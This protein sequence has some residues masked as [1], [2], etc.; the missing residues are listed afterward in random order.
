MKHKL[1]RIQTSLARTLLLAT[2]ALLAAMPINI[3]AGSF[4]AGN[5]V[6]LQSDT[7]TSAAASVS[8]LEFQTSGTGQSAV[9]TVALPTTVAA[10]PANAA[11]TQSGSATSEGYLSRSQD[12]TCLLAAGYNVA[13]GTASVAGTT[14]DRVVARINASGSV[15]TTTRPFGYSAN[16]IRA[17]AS[18]SGSTIYVAGPGAGITTLAFGSQPGSATTINSGNTRSVGIFGNQL[19]GAGTIGTL[20][21]V[22]SGLPTSSSTFTA[23][24]AAIGGTSANQFYFLD[25]DAGV[26][27]VDEVVIADGT[28]GLKKYSFDGTAWTL[29]GTITGS[30]FGVVIVANGSGTDI[31]ATTGTGAAAANN[32]VKYTD[33][34]AYNATG[35]FSSSTILATAAAGKAFR[36]LA[37]APVSSVTVNNTGTPAAGSI[38]TGTANQPLFGFQLSSAGSSSTFTAL[39]LTTAGT[40]TTSDLSNFRVVWDA[41]NSGTYNAGDVIVS[42]SA[43]S[44]ANPI[45][46]TFSGQTLSGSSNYLVIAD[47][48]AGATVGHT[49]TGSIAAAGDVTTSI[50]PIGTATGNQ[51]TVAAAV[52][53]LTMSAVPSSESTAISSLTN[54]ATISTTSQGVPVWQV[55]F[56]NPAGNAGAVTI[57]GLTFLQ[58]ANNGVV[59]WANTIQAAELFDGSTALGA[60]TIGATNIT[61]TGLSKAVTDGS[62]KTFTLQISLKST[63]GALKDNAHFQFA[64]AAAGVTL[65][66]N[67]GVTTAAINSDQTQNPITVVAS[68]LAFTL[69]PNYVITNTAFTA[70]VSAQDANGNLDVDNTS[71]VTISLATGSGNL[72]GITSLLLTGGN[73]SSTSLVYDTLGLFSL[74]ATDDGSVLTAATSASLSAH[75]APAL[76]EVVMPQNLQGGNSSKR[77]P[78]AYR[79]AISNLLPSATYRYYNQV[80]IGSD[81]AT[82]D[83]AGN[84]IFASASGSFGRTTG[85]SMSSAGNYGTFTTDANGSYAGWFISEPT[86]NAGKFG[87]AGTQDYM[88]IMLNDG[89]GG[90]GVFSRV[91][92]PDYAT[93][94]A[95]G[96]DTASGTGIYGNSLA[97][98]KNFAVLYDNTA[99]TGRPLA[100]TVVEDDGAAE[101]IANSY[102]LFYN[103]NVNGVAGAW[104]TLVPNSNAN[105]VQRIEQRALTDGSLLGVNT[106]ASGVW[107]STVS[108]VNPAGGDITPIFITATDAP[109]IPANDTVTYDGNGST[110]GAVPTDAN[111]YAA[112]ATVTVLGNTGSLVKLGA[113]FAGWNTA[114]DGSGTSY[115]PGNTFSIAASLSLYAQWVVV[116]AVTGSSVTGGNLLI[117]FTGSSSDSIGSF[118]VVGTTNLLNPMT[119]IPATIS[120]PAAGVFR[121]TIPTGSAPALFYRIKR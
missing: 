117:D 72:A 2:S 94:L 93:V 37:L 116:P 75:P 41:D 79:V 59:S 65:T 52:Y 15:D 69:A 21:T 61:F 77:L 13:V 67:N 26:A 89:N 11:L 18:V 121:A 103:N 32:L 54:D 3:R 118:S 80:V 9:N 105:G 22:G 110:G 30:F 112:G 115:S 82:S 50:T 85:P 4:T 63:A 62:S 58:G 113:T 98:A 27:G 108:T 114:A 66:G 84:C 95:F 38:T 48:A 56:N 57:T 120:S 17:A 99:G 47:V 86:G 55:T 34:A 53:D 60:G 92:T 36:G 119:A 24:A 31:Y 76:T 104:G 106:A 81:A 25:R 29:R 14:A 70:Q 68:K 8:L 44:L 111:S 71:S 78:F 46:F 12:G 28:S 96:T 83:G 51:Q 43:Q 74:T 88:R 101:N 100:A 19:Y 109:L 45:N 87:T 6:V 1:T 97:T 33:S 49:F 20:G 91:T 40:A 16:N 5:L 90:T 64:L 35:S 107:P 23:L 73:K 102:V 7:Q 42:S 39:K 10:A